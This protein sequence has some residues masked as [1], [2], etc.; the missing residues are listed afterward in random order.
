MIL[1]PMDS[2]RGN[3]E[4]M[5]RGTFGNVRIKNRLVKPK[6]GGFTV[7]FPENEEM[8]I[9]D[10]AEKYQAE[11]VPLIVLAG[12]EYGTGSSRDWAAKGSLLLGVR[13]IIAESFERIH[14][15]NLVGMGVLPLIFKTSENSDILGLDGSE[16]YDISGIE[17]MK[18]R[19]KLRVK[20]KKKD[21]TEI[22][23]D[24]IARLDNQIEVEY[25]KCGGI[26][27]YVLR[28]IKEV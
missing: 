22:V 6:E 25:I 4:V 20:A 11:G 15:S 9:F 17:D 18:P 27:Q 13:A 8:F 19:K 7:K 23:F 28:N 21:G 26:L 12:K 16:T 24:V 2:R 5:K 10:A 1:T 3:Y 14:R